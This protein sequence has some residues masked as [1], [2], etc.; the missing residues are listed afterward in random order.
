ML[1]IDIVK[2]SPQIS[3]G[4]KETKRDLN[5]RALWY[6]RTKER[7]IN[8][9]KEWIY[10][11]LRKRMEKYKKMRVKEQGIELY[12]KDVWKKERTND[13]MHKGDKKCKRMNERTNERSKERRGNQQTNKYTTNEWQTSVQ[14]SGWTNQETNQATNRANERNKLRTTNEWMCKFTLNLN[15]VFTYLDMCHCWA[16]T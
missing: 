3:R 4:L 7:K 9:T 14:A 12:R 6:K 8:R 10:K 16:R 2:E 1:Q 13:R 5:V 11:R 15:T